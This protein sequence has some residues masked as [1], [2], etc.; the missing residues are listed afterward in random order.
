MG[1]DGS[2]KAGVKLKIQAAGRTIDVSP[3][4]LGW[5]FWFAHSSAIKSD[6]PIYIKPAL[7]A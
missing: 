1:K 3:A 7:Q 2:K 6:S 5:F 4:F